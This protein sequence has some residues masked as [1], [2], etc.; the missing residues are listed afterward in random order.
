[1]NRVR[2]ILASLWY[3]R[4]QHIAVFLATVISTGVLTGALIVGDSVKYSLTNLVDKRLGN[5]EY[6]LV[7]GDRFVSSQ[8]A[9]KIAKDLN[10]PTASVLMMQG[11]AIN[12]QNHKRINKAQIIG[13]DNSF[14]TLSNINIPE[15]NIGEAII[16]Q[17]TAE[18]L[19]LKIDDE[20]LLRIKNADVIPLNTPFTN[21]ED[22][23]VALKL[24]IVGLADNDKLG[25]FSFRSNQNSPYNIFINR[26]FLAKKLELKDLSNI[27]VT[28]GSAS[29]T[30]NE[31][32]NSLKNCWTLKDA[33]L[34]VNQ[35]EKNGTFELISNRIFIDKPISIKISDIGPSSEEILTYFVNSISFNNKETPY[36]FITSASDSFLG[37]PLS[38]NEIIINSWLANDLNANIGDTLHVTY[39]VTGPLRTLAEETRQFT[40]KRIIHSDDLLADQDLMP[41]FPGLTDAGNCKDWETGIP[42]DLKKIRDKDEKYWEDF[43]G[44]PK[45]FISLEKGLEIWDNRFGNYT[46]V[47]YNGNITKDELE[48]EILS[49]ISPSDINL[50][51][52]DV[53]TEGVNA[54]SNGIDFGELFLSLSFFVIAA[55]ILLTI[56]TYS[57]NAE[58]R[59]SEVGVLT[60]LGF[61]KKQII[62]LRFYESVIP[63]IISSVIGGLLGILYNKSI[64]S[65][66]NSIWNDAVHADILDIYINPSTVVIGI[67][68]GVI[69]SLLSIYIVTKVKLKRTTISVINDI[70][71]G[72]KKGKKMF[73][74]LMSI[75]GLAGSIGIGIYSVLN[76]SD[77]SSS[78]TLSAGFL[79][80]VGCIALL[81]IILIPRTDGNI[82]LKNTNGI[83]QLAIKNARRNIV[84]SIAVIALLAIG[85]FTIIIT[86]ANRLTFSGTEN[87][88]ESGTGGYSFW[89][90]NT[91]P[92]LH[93]LNTD[94]GKKQ[95]GLEDEPILNNVNF[96]QFHK[97]PGDD[98]SCLNLNQVQLPQIIGVPANK[99]DS[100]HA[101]SFAK[102]YSEYSSPWLELNKDYGSG[103]IPAFADQTVIQWGLLK[104][105]GDTLIYTNESGENIKLLLV[106]GLSSSVFQGNILI[107]D[108]AFIANF[109]SSSGSEIML[110]DIQGD[111]TKEVENL[112]TNQLADYGVEINSASERL[113]GFY[114][115]TNTYLTIFMILGGLGVILGTIGLGIVLIRNMIERKHEI[116]IL[117]ALGF[118]KSQIFNLIL[119]ENIF[120]L[121]SGIVIGVLS[122][123]IGI[124]P[125]LL[126][127]AF[128]IPGSFLF[129]V[130][131]GVFISGLL[132]IY[133]P[134]KFMMKK[135]LIKN[136]SQE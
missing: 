104:S 75:L 115:V 14:W 38:K 123:F 36:S 134:A 26:D 18:K 40:V 113:A 82:T 83:N 54:A 60:A 128:H 76:L 48:K 43:K 11:I 59:M 133:I 109:P 92:L 17:N 28:D 42:I 63:I 125:S 80:L 73:L 108:S 19:N 72:I 55:A 93:N 20:I 10:I 120:L 78:L 116:A 22:N 52:R 64:I 13:T 121:I 1:M 124:L 118:N 129:L 51:F 67:L 69:I 57:L 50:S 32:N 127:P 91:V 68:I 77:I 94:D 102:L 110:V 81:V 132:W 66:L 117:G 71:I 6:A 95:Y 21:I 46:A 131:L 122:A 5:I 3:F 2:F 35:I 79:F 53:R 106:G 24:T 7:S 65:G 49:K 99:F 56:L 39:F 74:Y 44:T 70:T 8:L 107:S 29:I 15:L 47:R 34:Q 114:S 30:E 96:V 88:R 9:S 135:D 23:N 100:L 31:L 27:I 12:S 98:A 105:V 90:E 130:V 58:S 87:Q 126:S 136:L 101:F 4:K 37:E 45:G 25:Q 16:S 112:L 86:G 89:V 97:L 61:S 62:S 111:N 33:G 103:I 41:T 119:T 85:T 84:R